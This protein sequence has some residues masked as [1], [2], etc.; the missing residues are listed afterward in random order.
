MSSENGE[1]KKE[2]HLPPPIFRDA[3]LL[4]FPG[5]NLSS[6]HT[7]G[8]SDSSLNMNL[9]WNTL[10]KFGWIIFPY[11]SNHR[12]S[13]DWWVSNHLSPWYLGSLTIL[14]WL[15]GGAR[16]NPIL[17]GQ[18][19]KPLLFRLGDG[20]LPNYIWDSMGCQYK[21]PYKPIRIQWFMSLVGFVAVAHL[22]APNC[23]LFGAFKPPN[24]EGFFH[25]N[26]QQGSFPGRN[27][28]VDG[29]NPKQPPGMYKAL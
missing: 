21:D 3:L 18:C 19:S 28:T 4:V 10:D 12:T 17:T 22:E 15:E 24:K 13:D 23:C 1:S 2:I 27:G 7:L 26:Q 11:R 8:E 5:W 25:S 29:R 14:R 6:N 16:T 9:I 20:I